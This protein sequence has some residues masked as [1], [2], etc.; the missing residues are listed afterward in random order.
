[1]QVYDPESPGYMMFLMSYLVTIPVEF[2]L[3]RAVVYAALCDLRRYPE[4][5]SGMKSV[6]D[7]GPMRPGLVYQT[8]TNLLGKENAATVEVVQLVPDQAIVLQ[9]HAGLVE[10]RAVYEL[11]DSGPDSCKVICTLKFTFNH[12]IFQLAQSAVE[13]MTEDRIRGDLEKLRDL[14]AKTPIS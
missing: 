7:P 4:W 10:F 12:L 2:P 14:L 11:A 1:M 3:P 5:T 9:S 6:S 13:S 8:K